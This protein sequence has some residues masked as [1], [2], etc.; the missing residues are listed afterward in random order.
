MGHGGKYMNLKR[1]LI[2]GKKMTEYMECSSKECP[3]KVFDSSSE[4]NQQKPILVESINEFLKLK[5]QEV[6]K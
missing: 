1:C 5:N 2:C 3:F 4:K 6:I